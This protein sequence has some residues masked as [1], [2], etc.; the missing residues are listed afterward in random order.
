MINAAGK[1]GNVLVVLAEGLA[2]VVLKFAL[3][4]H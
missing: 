4:R 2:K 1:M 3:L